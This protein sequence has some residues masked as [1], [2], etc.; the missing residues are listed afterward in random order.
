MVKVLYTAK[1]VRSAIEDIFRKGKSGRRVAV[2]AYVGDGADVYLPFPENVQVI[3]SPTPGATNPNAIR[4]L[5]SRGANVLFVDKLHMKVYWS[6]GSGVVVTSAN[7]STNALGVGGLKEAGVLLESELLDIDKLLAPLVLRPAA[8]ELDDLDRKHRDYYKRNPRNKRLLEPSFASWFRS[9]ERERWKLLV[10]ED[11]CD[12]PISRA[13]H[14]RSQTEIGREPT[15]WA[16]SA[17]RTV[18]ENEWVLCAALRPEDSESF[19]W[20]YVDHVQKVSPKDEAYA[21]EYPYEIVQLRPLKTYAPPPFAVDSKFK[22]AFRRAAAK[23]KIESETASPISPQS[24]LLEAL[25]S[26]LAK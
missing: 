5:M 26:L 9:P 20:L 12:E 10:C 21:K 25:R 6:A 23:L 16:W 17:E 19:S 24:E 11:F 4:D 13:S 18:E 14:D 22:N 1:E 7:L 2:S 8:P 3:C 15:T